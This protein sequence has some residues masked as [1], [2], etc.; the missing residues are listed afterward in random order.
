MAPSAN[1]YLIAYREGPGRRR[2]LDAVLAWL[3]E[4]GELEIILVEQDSY[5]RLTADTL[6]A[7]GKLLFARNTGPFNKSWGLNVAAR[8][9]GSDVI[10]IG[11]ADMVTDPGELRRCFASCRERFD[12]VNPY[13]RLVDLS[14]SQTRAYTD[15]LLALADIPRSGNTDRT[16]GGEHPPFCGG[17]C[18]FRREVFFALGGMDESFQGW[19]GEDDALSLNL[20]RYT[21]NTAVYRAG[22]A[23]HLWHERAAADRVSPDYLRN[24]RRLRELASWNDIQWRT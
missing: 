18:M 10:A 2:A 16:T 17:I 4:I 6:P 7:N 13:A 20:A 22:I 11:D 19:G 24:V 14:E 3:G 12:A 5:P 1:S 9:A 15:G 21:T 23:Y 8:N